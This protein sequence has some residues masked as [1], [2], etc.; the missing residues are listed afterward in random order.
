MGVFQ[1]DCGR[2]KTEFELLWEKRI[3][4]AMVLISMG[5]GHKLQRL[6]YVFV[7]IVFFV[8]FFR[9][10]LFAKRRFIMQQ[11]VSLSTKIETVAAVPFNIF[12]GSL[13]VIFKMRTRRFIIE[14]IS[15]DNRWAFQ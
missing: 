8:D 11:L 15:N 13:R 6:G 9:I 14:K 7:F 10:L 3:F 2:M 1:F 4:L 12:M 5:H